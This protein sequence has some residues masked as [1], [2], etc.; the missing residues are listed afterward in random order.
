MHRF[1]ALVAIVTA[2]G[3]GFAISNGAPTTAQ[4]D[5]AASAA[6][7]IVGAW[8]FVWNF[9]YGPLVSYGIFH[10]DGTSI[11]EPYV[12]GPLHFGVWQ[13]TGARTADLTFHNLYPWEEKTAEGEGRFSLT[14]D[15][16]GNAI[17]GPGVYVSRYIEDGGLEYHF[18]ATMP[19]TRVEVAPL[20]SE[21]ALIGETAD[22]ATPAP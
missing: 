10:A 19:G 12:D 6:H 22:A 15:T 16:A 13:P 21:A 7:P 2:F 18:E 3:I 5:A 14:V 1:V 17:D 8:R 11:A 4:E 9:G 20:V